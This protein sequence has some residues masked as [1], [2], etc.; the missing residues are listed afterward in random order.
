MILVTHDHADHMAALDPILALLGY[1]DI[2]WAHTFGENKKLIILGNDS[3]TERYK[4]YNEEGRKDT[5]KVLSFQAWEARKI[6]KELKSLLV[7]PQALRI[8]AVSTWGHEDAGGSGAQGVM[9]SIGT[10]AESSSVLFTSDMG[11]IDA[12]QRELRRKPKS[13]IVSPGKS[14]TEAIK[15]ATIVVVHVSAIPL[16]QLRVLAGL[17]QTPPS[18]EAETALFEGIW[19]ALRKQIEEKLSS[20]QVPDKIWA[21]KRRFLVRQLQFGFHSSPIADD[22]GPSSELRVSPLSPCDELERHSERHLYLD[23]LLSIAERMK[24]GG[25]EKLLLIGE[26]HEELGTFRTR[27]ARALNEFL[28]DDSDSYALTADIGLTARVRESSDS[29]IEIL[30]TTCALDNDLVDVERFHAPDEICEVC[31]KGE[32]EGIFYN[33]KMHD[34]QR[35]PQPTWVER[36]ERYDPFGR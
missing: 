13:R 29:A 6:G 4:F 30:C 34:P 24:R 28:F 9:L 16:P 3:V 7:P 19:E 1:R 32:D 22:D 26:L 14:I 10:G 2:L 8:E 33:C 23:G 17:Q 20:D 36:V 35:Q 31:V 25:G 11:P 27:I 21:L 15:E 5:V 18:F 12:K